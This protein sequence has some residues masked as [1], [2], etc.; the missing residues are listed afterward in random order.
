M[1]AHPIMSGDTI[2]V[3]HNGIIEN[4]DALRVDCARLY[5]SRA[6]R[7]RGDRA[8]DPHL[9]RDDLFDAV[10]RAVKRLHARIAVL[11]AKEPQRLVAARPARRS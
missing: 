7:H 5:V 8:P 6:D 3:V 2:A 9:Y 4:H 1:N 11:S 10:V